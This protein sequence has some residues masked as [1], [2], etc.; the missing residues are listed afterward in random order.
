MKKERKRRL[1][2]LIFALITSRAP[3]TYLPTYLPTIRKRKLVF[4]QFHSVCLQLLPPIDININKPTTTFQLLPS[5]YYLPTTTYLLR[6]TYYDLP[7]TTYLLRPTYYDP[8]TTTH[9]LPPTYYHLPTTTYQLR[10]TN[11]DLPT[12]TYLLRPTN[13]DLPTTTYPL[14]PIGITVINLIVINYLP[15]STYRYHINKPSYYYLQV[16]HQ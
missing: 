16:S 12:T 5:N 13:F 1:L 9:L 7:N 6:P 2:F 14:L 4:E 8:P 11:Y 3:V 15:I 10:P